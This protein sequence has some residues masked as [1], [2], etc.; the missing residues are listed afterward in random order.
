MRARQAEDLAQRNAEEQ[1][2]LARRS[3]QL[4]D[5]LTAARTEALSANTDVVA[6]RADLCA[7][8]IRANQQA[9]L[10]GKFEGES[11]SLDDELRAAQEVSSGTLLEL[12]AS[13]AEAEA[14]R[15]GRAQ[16]KAE[17]ERDASAEGERCQ[18]LVCGA[19]ADDEGAR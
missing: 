5:E 7:A 16:D 11:A 9:A 17:G 15:A 13:R 10:V 2:E 19:H 6:A 12:E 4:V 14:L 1:E 18:R 3:E 8:T